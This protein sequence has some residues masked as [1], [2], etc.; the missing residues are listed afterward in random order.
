VLLVFMVLALVDISSGEPD[1][2]LEWR[3][4]RAALVVLAAFHVC[5]LVALSRRAALG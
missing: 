2:V 4:V 1:L 5:A 3:V